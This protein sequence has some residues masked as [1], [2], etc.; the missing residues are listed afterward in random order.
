MIIIERKKEEKLYAEEN[1]ESNIWGIHLLLYV[2]NLK[3]VEYNLNDNLTVS[4]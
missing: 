2:V 3:S 1:C 4:I